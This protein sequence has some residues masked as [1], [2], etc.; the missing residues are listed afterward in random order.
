[1]NSNPWQRWVSDTN[2]R[3]SLRAQTPLI[4]VARKL[5]KRDRTR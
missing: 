2:P 1:M 5:G 3:S 4:V